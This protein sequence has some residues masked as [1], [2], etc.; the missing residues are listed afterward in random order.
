MKKIMHVLM[1]ILMILS[2][3]M[4]TACDSS[5]DKMLQ[6]FNTEYFTL[7]P[8]PPLEKS[9]TD[10]SFSADQMLEKRY[11]F[12]KDY[13]SSLIAPE[14]G[15]KYDWTLQTEDEEGA[16]TES[17]CSE[18]IYDFMP[19]VDIKMDTETTLVLTVTDSSGMEYIDTALIIVINR[20]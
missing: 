4:F 15:V 3:L 13:A 10:A 8:T 18:R 12:I 17:V 1:M 5:Y 19:G 7:E 20:N 6:D 16:K 2:V 14:G 11:T 9:I